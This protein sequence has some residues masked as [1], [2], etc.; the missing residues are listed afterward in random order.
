MKTLREHR[1]AVEEEAG[2]KIVK[3]FLQLT[4]SFWDKVAEEVLSLDAFRSMIAEGGGR[5]SVTAALAV[6]DGTTALP[7]IDDDEFETLAV[8]I[9]DR[10]RREE[11]DAREA[12]ERPLA[13]GCLWVWHWKTGG[14]NSCRADTREEAISIAASMCSLVPNLETLRPVTRE[15]LRAVERRYGPYD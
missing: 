10:L 1:K 14:Y 2:E 3:T 13:F 12:Q 5:D 9:T 11:K 4:E 7:K 6:M 15:E 8:A